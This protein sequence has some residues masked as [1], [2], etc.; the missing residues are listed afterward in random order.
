MPEPGHGYT[1]RRDPLDA[2]RAVKWMTRLIVYTA[3]A[4]L[5]PLDHFLLGSPRPNGRQR[6][7][8]DSE[9]AEAGAHLEGG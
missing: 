7:L 9:L 2:M 4:L 6:C 3:V 8:P 1:S 5:A